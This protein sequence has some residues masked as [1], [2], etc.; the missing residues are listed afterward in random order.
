MKI[1]VCHWKICKW[2]FS[3]YISKRIEWDIKKYEL[4]NITLENCSC[5]WQCKLWPNV[6]IDG[7]IE[8]YSDPIKISKMIWDKIKQRKNTSKDMKNNKKEF[9]EEKL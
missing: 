4:G 1:Q 5:L 7:K 8:N 3:E 9:Y 2:K 6:I